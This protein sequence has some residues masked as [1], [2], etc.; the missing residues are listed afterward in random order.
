MKVGEAVLVMLEKAA[1]A[2]ES[3]EAKRDAEALRK[4][5]EFIKSDEGDALVG[6]VHA[7]AAYIN[8]Y[9]H[10]LPALQGLTVIMAGLVPEQ[11]EIAA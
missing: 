9:P 7:M 4:M 11:K 6:V 8:V 1:E 5:K 3:K 2:L 10:A